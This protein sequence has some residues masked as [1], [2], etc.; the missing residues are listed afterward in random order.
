[1]GKGER[2]RR[3]GTPEKTPDSPLRAPR[4]NNIKCPLARLSLFQEET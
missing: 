4:S 1:M 2:L 3:K